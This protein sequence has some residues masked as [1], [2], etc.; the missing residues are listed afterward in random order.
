MTNV[1]IEST[2]IIKNSDN[3]T[4]GYIDYE[5]N[6]VKQ[7]EIDQEYRGKGYGLKTV[8]EFLSDCKNLDYSCVYFVCV[9]NE[10]LHNIL[11]KPYFISETV[12][13]NEIPI[14]TKFNRSKQLHYRIK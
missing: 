1:N 9:T 12:N 7:I 13:S 4:I 3:K 8:K 2:G 5:E 11:T 6:V 14:N 10:K